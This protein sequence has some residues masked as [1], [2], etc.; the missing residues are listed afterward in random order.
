[1]GLFHLRWAFVLEDGTIKDGGEK[2]P[3]VKTDP[4]LNLAE[5]SPPE[6]IKKY[7]NVDC[8]GQMW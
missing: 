3:A 8:T 2:K 6:K 4:L 7:V 5:I 1:M